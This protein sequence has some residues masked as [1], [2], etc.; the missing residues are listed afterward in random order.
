MHGTTKEKSKK[1]F[2]FYVHLFVNDLDTKLQTEIGDLIP[3]GY[4][5]MILSLEIVSRTIFQSLC[6]LLRVIVK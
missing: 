5:T 3:F 1:S 4:K 2:S 6:F